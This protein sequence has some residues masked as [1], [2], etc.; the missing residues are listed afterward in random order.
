[1]GIADF[2]LP[3]LKRLYQAVSHKPRVVHV[4]IEGC[5]VVGGLF[6]AEFRVI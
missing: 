3:E 5:C 2:L 6:K 4:Y 1:M